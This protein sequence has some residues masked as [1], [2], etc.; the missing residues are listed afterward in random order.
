MFWLNTWMG[1]VHQPAS[2]K[3]R[4]WHHGVVHKKQPMTCGFVPYSLYSYGEHSC[5]SHCSAP[6]NIIYEFFALPES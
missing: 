4:S 5:T 1:F 2:E 6:T 3:G